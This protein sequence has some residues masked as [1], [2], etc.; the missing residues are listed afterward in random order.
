MRC[1]RQRGGGSVVLN[2]GGS[3][4]AGRQAANLP[5]VGKVTKQFA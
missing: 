3:K 4:Q 5:I 2:S 1:R